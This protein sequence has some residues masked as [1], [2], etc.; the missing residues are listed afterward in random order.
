ME[1]IGPTA[2]AP[3][4]AGPA[5]MHADA[6]FRMG[7]AHKA[8]GSP[9]QDYAL[10]GRDAALPFAV[11][12]DG[13][14]L[15][16]RTD[17]GARV[18]ALTA[19]R[20][21]LESAADC[22]PH[23]GDAGTFAARLI[24]SATEASL[25]LDLGSG[26]LDATLCF[27]RATADGGVDAWLFGDGLAAARTPCGTEVAIVDWAGN[28]PGYP[29]YLADPERLA[30]FLSESEAAARLGGRMACEVRRYLIAHD[31]TAALTGSEGHHAAAALNGIGFSW[32]PGAADVA[33]VMSDGAMQVSGAAWP[34]VVAAL[35]A[36]GSARTGAFVTRRMNRALA[37]LSKS[38]RRPAD[39]ISVAAIAA[40]VQD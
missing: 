25:A 32:L 36:F 4:S 27:V 7:S 16:G 13:C 23:P 38:G 3:V 34:E 20:L 30:L 33:A 6:H 19:R 12:S 15:S 24:A 2:S 22:L 39:D 21:L 8:D 37:S 5:F 29:A 9:C 14:S 17:V 26:D 18:I 31:G 1:T 35:M 10:A 11:L 40:A 28:L